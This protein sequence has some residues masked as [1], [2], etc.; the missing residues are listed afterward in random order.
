MKRRHAFGYNHFDTEIAAGEGAIDIV[1]SFQ[2]ELF[3]GFQFCHS[4]FAFLNSFQVLFN[5]SDY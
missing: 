2:A 3:I 5:L 1:S 4:P